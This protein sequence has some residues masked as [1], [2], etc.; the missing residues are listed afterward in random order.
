VECL[1]EVLVTLAANVKH[2]NVKKKNVS[3]GTCWC[4]PQNTSCSQE[5]PRASC[6]CVNIDRAVV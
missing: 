2:K 6:P 5:T 1:A 4:P 3:V